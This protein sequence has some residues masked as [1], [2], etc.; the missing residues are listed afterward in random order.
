MPDVTG[1]NHVVHPAA[2]HV[3]KTKEKLKIKVTED[4][5][6][7]CQ[8]IYEQVF[9]EVKNS[10]GKISYISKMCYSK[11]RTYFQNDHNF[12]SCTSQKCVT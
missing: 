2:A 4:P 10:I 3:R 8:L 9:S 7:P 6:T 1:H 5:F 12:K 11:Y